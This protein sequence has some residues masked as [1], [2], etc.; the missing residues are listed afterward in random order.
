[1]LIWFARPPVSRVTAEDSATLSRHAARRDL[2]RP[3]VADGTAT[4]MD[5]EGRPL[6]LRSCASLPG[7]GALAN[8]SEG[9]AAVV[10]RVVTRARRSAERMSGHA[11]STMGADRRRERR[12]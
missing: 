9:T 4:P 3:H 8:R 12:A 5:V 6:Q 2:R 7:P 10:P 11:G 1:M